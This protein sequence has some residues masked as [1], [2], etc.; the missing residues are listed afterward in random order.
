MLFDIDV[1]TRREDL[2]D[3]GLG[4]RYTLRGS[5]RRRLLSSLREDSM[6]QA[7]SRLRGSLQKQLNP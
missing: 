6:K 5:A 4:G 1:K 7:L 2:F 3:R